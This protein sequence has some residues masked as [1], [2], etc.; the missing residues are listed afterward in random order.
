[1]NDTIAYN[2][3][4]HHHHNEHI[5]SSM[6]H[7]SENDVIVYNT[8][9]RR[10]TKNSFSSKINKE[11]QICGGTATG[12]HFGAQSC[13][14]CTAFFRRAIVHKRV[15]KCRFNGNCNVTIF[16][17]NSCRACRMNKCLS[18]GMDPAAVQPHHDPIGRVHMK[19]QQISVITTT[20]QYAEMSEIHNYKYIPHQINEIEY[21]NNGYGP[22]VSLSPTYSIINNHGP[23]CCESQIPEVDNMFENSIFFYNR[24]LEQRRLI[25][26]YSNFNCLL[27]DEMPEAKEIK[28]GE[29]IKPEAYKVDLGILALLINDIRG[30][31]NI[32]SPKDKELMLKNIAIAT[33]FL[34]RHFISL[35]KGGLESQQLHFPDNTYVDLSN[36][37]NIELYNK[38]RH[39]SSNS[40]SDVGTEGGSHGDEPNFD[41]VKKILLVSVK[42][43]FN[44]LL[45][46]MKEIK[47]TTIEFVGLFLLSFFNPDL[48]GLSLEAANVCRERRNQIFKEWMN[49]YQKRCDN[50]G[51]EKMGNMILLLSCISEN[52]NNVQSAFHMIRVFKIFEY[53]K[54][55]EHLYLVDL[56]L[57][58]KILK[59][60]LN[61]KIDPCEDFYDFSCGKWVEETNIPEHEQEVL[62][63]NIPVVKIKQIFYESF[64]FGK[65]VYESVALDQLKYLLKVCILKGMKNK[66][67]LVKYN[68]KLCIEEFNELLIPAFN[69]IMI[70]YIFNDNIITKINDS[71]HV[72]FNNIKEAFKEEI[73][74]KK[75]IDDKR[76]SIAIDKINNIKYMFRYNKVRNGIKRMEKYYDNMI[77][78]HN[79]SFDN[80]LRKGKIFM[81]LR[82]NY[83]KWNQTFINILRPGASYWHDK[84][85]FI[86]YLGY[87]ME[88]IFDTKL[89]M[90]MKYGGYGSIIGHEII[91]SLDNNNI[92]YDKFGNKNNWWFDGITKEYDEKINCFLKQYGKEKETL[93]GFNVNGKVTL[94]ENLS[95]NG[96][97]KASFMAFK[98]YLNNLDIKEDKIPGFEKYSSEQIFFISFSQFWCSKSS[99]SASLYRIFNDNHSPNKIRVLLSLINQKEFSETFKCK[100]GSKMNPKKKCEL[101]RNMH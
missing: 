56:K 25:N 92:N 29:H 37:D 59:S 10:P 70:N 42:E 26:G 62:R 53:D 77:F 49:F 100:V 89:P 83:D 96:G 60:T 19:S 71:I 50:D 12:Y 39:H 87:L 91:H 75:W 35:K 8:N 1:M 73:K 34:E 58:S 90:S 82:T 67:E 93:S 4:Y 55:L 16:V 44:I 28:F 48:P 41:N 13:A 21:N 18:C 68:H 52:L 6:Q 72:L 66:D 32:E 3:H 97:V 61:E 43:T 69:S 5:Q 7:E 47:V 11:C 86:S 84:N 95:D 17:R 79:D 40:E 78:N 46:A 2:N 85:A 80:V 33:Y 9:N 65:I 101:W 14:A 74:T 31:E 99:K 76:K 23:T 54:M 24:K 51:I 38:P 15:F 22:E 20:P 98:K 45:E 88:P 64:I 27:T 57:A 81:K 94:N 30:Y 36:L 63:N